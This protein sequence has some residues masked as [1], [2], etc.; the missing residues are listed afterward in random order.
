[1][2]IQ[3]NGNFDDQLVELI[4]SLHERYGVQEN[5]VVNFFMFDDLSDACLFL[6]QNYAESGIVNIGV[7]RKA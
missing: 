7:G 6:M 3:S 1:M 5:R 2:S 4:F